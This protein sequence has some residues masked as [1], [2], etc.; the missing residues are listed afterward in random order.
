[1]VVV[2]QR[3]AECHDE[4]AHKGGLD[5]AHALRADPSVRLSAISKIRDRVRAFEM[6]PSDA[7]PM[8]EGERSALLLACDATL[9]REVPQLKPSP[10]RVTVRRLSRTHWDRCIEDLFGVASKQSNA[11]PADDL[12]YGFDSIGDAMSF[13]TLHLEAYLAAAE[14][15]AAQVFV[16][17]DGA[18]PIRTI[19]GEAMDL[20]HGPGFG[21][22]SDV[23]VLYANATIGAAFDAVRDGTFRISVHAG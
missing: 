16:D 14:D 19:E 6:P 15:V 12:G 1:M 3:C 17:E 13:S 9:A 18:T 21:S 2:E 8:T 23:A 22:D 11:F 7:D 4:S 10:G 20:V 5:I